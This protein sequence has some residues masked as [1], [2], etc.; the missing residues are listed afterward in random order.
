M[1]T[2]RK[3]RD[4]QKNPIYAEPE[5]SWRE[6]TFDRERRPTVLTVLKRRPNCREASLDK[7]NDLAHWANSSRIDDEGQS[8]PRHDPTRKGPPFWAAVLSA[9]VNDV[10]DE[11]AQTLLFDDAQPIVWTSDDAF[12]YI[13][14][15]RREN[16]RPIESHTPEKKI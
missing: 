11:S 6:Q 16:P 5:R 4:F 13:L 1:H 2:E 3:P 10:S 8:C 15:D 12:L 14:P 9:T 7:F